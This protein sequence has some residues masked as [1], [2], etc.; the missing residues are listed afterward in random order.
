[1]STHA[2]IAKKINENSYRTI[3]CHCDG[4][5]EWVG[6]ILVEDYNTPDKVDRL[7]NLGDLSVL[8]SKLDPNPE[9]PHSFDNPQ[10]G[11]TIAYGRDRRE[12]DVDARVMTF[13]DLADRNHCIS[14]VYIYT[15]DKG[16]Q[17][18]KPWS[19]DHSLKDVRT[20]LAQGIIH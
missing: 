2:F 12:K 10:T 19:D 9:F 7:I 1:M 4:Y 14:Y 3:Y 16:W 11:V 8:Q 20:A 6:R 13:G 15:E 17:Y 5:L 18:F